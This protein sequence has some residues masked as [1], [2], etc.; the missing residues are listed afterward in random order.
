MDLQFWN[1]IILELLIVTALFIDIRQQRIPNVI[2]AVGLV[3]GVV[4][5]ILTDSFEDRIK[6]FALVFFAFILMYIIG[7]VCAGDVK[8][9]MACSVF[10]GYEVS[11]ISIFTIAIAGL[12]IS[13][14]TLSVNGKLIEFMRFS[15]NEIKYRAISLTTFKRG[16]L[17][18]PHIENP[19]NI[20]YMY[21]VAIGINAALF[22]R[23]FLLK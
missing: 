12:F 16:V 2:V 13:A 10:M 3:I 5:A 9:M 17:E 21:A 8:F 14:V 15:W 11:Y 6:A 7:Y 23:G 4:M 20:P 19:T 22:V 18:K 1:I